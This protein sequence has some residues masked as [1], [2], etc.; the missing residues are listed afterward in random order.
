MNRAAPAT[1]ERDADRSREAILNAA[2]RLFAEGGLEGASLQAIGAAA[3]VSRGLPNYLFGAKEGLYRAV[4]DRLLQAERDAVVAAQARLMDEGIGSEAV[5]AAAIRGHLEFL[6]ARPAF[7][8]LL[9]REA[10]RGGGELRATS[11]FPAVLRTGRAIIEREQARG[12][13][14]TGDPDR[15]LMSVLALCWFPFTHAAT[16]AREL[17]T[18]IA[19]P[20]FLDTHTAFIVRTLFDGIRPRRDP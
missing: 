20:A 8:K 9:E 13:I 3:G 6:L 5:F 19:D 18:D 4:L 7:L 11:S 17:G 15:L 1:R 10:L 12:G 14:V 2:E 16:V